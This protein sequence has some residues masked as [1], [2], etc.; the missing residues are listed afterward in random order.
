V[1]RTPDEAAVFFEGTELTYAEFDRRVDALAHRLIDRGV[2]PESVVGLAMNRSIELLV[3]MYAVLRAGG[4]YLP[5]DLTHP[6]DRLA[7][8]LATARPACILTT[9]SDG[10]ASV[11]VPVIEID[12]IDLAGSPR[13]PVTDAHRLA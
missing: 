5:I 1:A 2:G 11:N 4:A 7:Y 13:E 6:A 3:G 12:S 9:S 8:V 10:F